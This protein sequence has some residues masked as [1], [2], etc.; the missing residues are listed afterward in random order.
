MRAQLLAMRQAGDALGP[1][2]GEGERPFRAALMAR[3][4]EVRRRVQNDASFPVSFSVVRAVE[5]IFMWFHV[6]VLSLSWQNIVC[7]DIV[8]SMP[9]QNLRWFLQVDNVEGVNTGQR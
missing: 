5:N 6:F 9:T 8:C 3:L 7:S 1:P 2:G 4:A